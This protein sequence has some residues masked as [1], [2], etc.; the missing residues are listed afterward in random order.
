VNINGAP[1][2][3]DRS[4]VHLEA[5]KITSELMIALFDR[6][7]ACNPTRRAITAVLNSASYNRS[8]AIKAYLARDGFRIRLVYLPPYPPNLNLIERL[9]WL[10]KKI[11]LW[12][13][14]YATFA[15]FK[16][17]IDGYFQQLGAYHEQLVSLVTDQFVT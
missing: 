11:A 8:A 13:E 6:L 16:M 3:P 2:W 4:L 5:E 9:W 15:K 17:A 7:E 12:N 1:S 14:Y 10:F